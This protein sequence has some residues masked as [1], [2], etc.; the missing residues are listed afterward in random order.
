MMTRIF[1]CLAL[2]SLALVAGCSS[3]PYVARLA[4]DSPRIGSN[5]IYIVS[6]GWH[7]GLVLPAKEI[8]SRLPALKNRFGNTPYIEFGWGDKGFYQANEITTG[9]TFRA[10]FW[11]SGSVIH[12][13]AV[14]GEPL[15]YF[16]NSD[17]Q[18]LCLSDVAASSLVDFV[19]NSFVKNEQGEIVTLQNGIYGNSQFYDGVGDY[20]LLNTCNK[21]TAKGLQNAG[22]DISPTFKLTAGSVMNYVHGQINTCSEPIVKRGALE[23][24]P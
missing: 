10:M 12:A 23:L 4:E 3:K 5:E 19:V 7:T 21:W 6:H 1:F 14:T 16:Q 13:V 11:S 20:H 18:Q 15:K 24:A 9:L 17:I 2:L 22:F 8:Q